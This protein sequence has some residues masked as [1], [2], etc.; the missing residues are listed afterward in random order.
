MSFRRVAPE[1]AWKVAITWSRP[2]SYENVINSEYTYGYD[3]SHWLYMILGYHGSAQRKIFY[4]GKVY[5][6]FVGDRLRHPD[7]VRRYSKL[8]KKYPN[9][10]LRVS[11]GTIHVKNGK[12]TKQRVDQIE[13]MLIYTAGET[14]RHIINKSKLWTLRVNEHYMIDNS[15]YHS[16]LPKEIHYG[17]FA[18]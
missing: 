10:K 13:T 4:V 1:A 7:H 2:I 5:D 11:L 3:Y 6:S 17:I 14:Q 18:R 8:K 12:I 15:G 9:H 16:P